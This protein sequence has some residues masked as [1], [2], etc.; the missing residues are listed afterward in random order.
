[1]LFS[2]EFSTSVSFRILYKTFDQSSGVVLVVGLPYF[3]G[4]KP[5]LPRKR[6][7]TI[8][9]YSVFLPSAVSIVGGMKWCDYEMEVYYLH[10]LLMNCFSAATPALGVVKCP[11][12]AENVWSH[13]TPFN[14]LRTKV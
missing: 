10:S 6:L 9:D 4:G 13:P 3:L 14:D 2:F 1:M 8:T 11:Y 5:S 12:D 7:A